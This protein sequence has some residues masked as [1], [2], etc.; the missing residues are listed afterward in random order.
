MANEQKTN[1]YWTTAKVNE[2][3]R[4]ADEDGIDFK[5]VD[6]PFHENDPELRKGNILFELT[7]EEVAELKK[8]ASDVIYFANTYCNAM[9]DDG[10]KKIT[11]RDYQE[12]ILKQY[13]DNR[14]NIFLSPRQSGKCLT[15]NSSVTID[16]K[17]IP[18]YRIFKKQ[19][20]IIYIL[21]LFLYK[22]YNIM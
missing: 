5:E 15:Q 19:G 9:T 14:F 16:G 21:K 7:P 18:L 11:L 17:N 2:I 3:I 22:I 4:R 8:C 6:N 12:Q 13:Q 20:K 10:I 1:N